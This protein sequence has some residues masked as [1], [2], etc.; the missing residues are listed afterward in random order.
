MSIKK[1]QIL[2]FTL[3]TL[4]STSFAATTESSV[5]EGK[6][7]STENK[8]YNAKVLVP[9]Y[10]LTNCKP[11][12]SSKCEE[13]PGGA[14][15]GRPG[16]ETNGKHQL[17]LCENAD[18]DDDDSDLVEAFQSCER[19]RWDEDYLMMRLQGLCMILAFLSLRN[20]KREKASSE[21]LFD[22]RKR[23]AQ[24]GN[25]NTNGNAQNQEMV[26]LNTIRQ[27][28]FRD[29][30]TGMLSLH[31]LSQ[32]SEEWT[33]LFHSGWT[34]IFLGDSNWCLS[35]T[36]QYSQT[37]LWKCVDYCCILDRFHI[38]TFAHIL[39]SLISMKLLE[40]IKNHLIGL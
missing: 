8:S 38:N 15:S 28:S 23:I 31:S 3:Y 21:S 16:C 5:N 1:V 25:S 13:C 6:G 30:E 18:N 7:N 4:L 12:P 9:T 37:R 39:S 40:T 27:E 17:H 26:P 34:V 36:L 10:L 29:E 24:M 32:G 2:F 14:H 33:I 11:A 20:V 22:Q 35:T 19:T